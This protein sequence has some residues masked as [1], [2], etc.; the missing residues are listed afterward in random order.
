VPASPTHNP[1]DA[2][3]QPAPARFSLIGAFPHSGYTHQIRAHLA[4]LRQPI[5]GDPLYKSLHPSDRA[6]TSPALPFLRTALHAKGITLTH[7]ISEQLLT[8]QAVYPPDFQE[9]LAFLSY[10]IKPQLG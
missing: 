9:T 7:P 1:P 5:Y 8:F 6:G 3:A 4:A 10:Y 2:A